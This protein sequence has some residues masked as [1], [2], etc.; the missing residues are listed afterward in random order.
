VD[1]PSLGFAGELPPEWQQRSMFAIGPEWCCSTRIGSIQPMKHAKT[2]IHSEV[3]VA[4][5]ALNV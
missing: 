3:S 1:L 5:H 4:I 2:A